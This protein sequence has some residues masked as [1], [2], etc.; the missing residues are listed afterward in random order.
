MKSVRHL[1]LLGVAAA[2]TACVPQ[3]APPPPQPKPRQLPPRPLLPP[4]P[5]AA[6]DWRDMPLTPGNWYYRNEPTVSQALFGPANSEANFIVRC[7]KARRQVTLWRE[8]LTSGNTMT[9]RTSFT[10]RNVPATV[11]REPLPYVIATVAARDPA[12]DSMVFSRGRFTIEA[13]GLPMLVIPA[14]PEPARVVED[15]RA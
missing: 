10:A 8:G 3:Q 11:Q 4:P 2:V 7:E 9:V 13:P 6:R 1:A 15:C 12:L 5:P 14:W